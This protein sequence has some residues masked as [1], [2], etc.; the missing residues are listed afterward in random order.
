M[1]TTAKY[2]KK[3]E[4]CITEANDQPHGTD[5]AADAKATLDFREAEIYATLAV[6]S[7]IDDVFNQLERIAF[8]AGG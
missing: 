5:P 4:D 2:A 7:A 3:A 6:A 1:E 8:N